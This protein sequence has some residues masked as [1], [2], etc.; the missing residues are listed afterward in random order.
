MQQF[1]FIVG[2][3]SSGTELLK[4]VL[5]AHESI[6]LGG[7]YPFLL[8]VA[9]RFPPALLPGEVREVERSLVRRDVYRQLRRRALTV[10]ELRACRTFADVYGRLV[11]D[12]PA[13][14]LGNK[15]PQYAERLRELHGVFPE[16]RVILL[17]RDVRDVCLSW[18][19]KWGKDPLWCASKWDTRMTA[20]RSALEDLY[21]PAGLIVRFEDILADVAEVSRRVCT[22][23]HLPYDEGMTRFHENED[24][25][26]DGHLNYGGEILAHNQQ[27]WRTQ[28]DPEMIRR[29]EEIAWQSLAAFGYERE[30]AA[31]PWPLT[32]GE[33]RRARRADIVA[34]AVVGNRAVSGSRTAYKLMALR[35]ELL[36]LAA[37]VRRRLTPRTE[38]PG[39]RAG[40]HLFLAWS[41]ISRPEAIEPFFGFR[42]VFLSWNLP[43]RWARAIEYVLKSLQTGWML[44][45]RRPS[46]VW[47][48]LAPTPLLYVAVIVKRVVRRRMAL[49]ADCHNSMFRR[50]WFAFPWARRA[51]NA[52]DL[53][54]VHNRQVLADACQKGIDGDRLAILEGRPAMHLPQGSDERGGTPRVVFPCGFGDDEPVAEVLDAARQMPDVEVI[55]T[56]NLDRA[57]GRY[58]FSALPA[59]VRLTGFLPSADFNRLVGEASLVLGL[60]TREGVQLNVATEAVG[61]G[62]PLV[63]ADTVLLRELYHRGAVFVDP[64]SGSAIADG[65]RSGLADWNRLRREVLELRAEQEAGWLSRA[66]AIAE[67][68]AGQSSGGGGRSGAEAASR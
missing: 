31:A 6:W 27:K 24:E 66:G 34:L 5:R 1:L 33:R 20:A 11:A 2:F 21:G 58:D 46:I 26:L 52:C 43:R 35:V 25:Q 22:L 53:V 47:V 29:I 17:V 37:R 15:T 13:H 39:G 55:I 3:P 16:S 57:R 60:T 28:F 4:T 59:N 67:R 65:I 41:Y 48:Q 64:R 50:P 7:E 49:I 44:V 40:P 54:I 19:R 12:R 61:M 30:Y 10:E 18:R 38:S 23:L 42:L 32:P 51:L 9:C 68:L 62:T 36:K 56:G 14:W 45:S 8:D 63:I